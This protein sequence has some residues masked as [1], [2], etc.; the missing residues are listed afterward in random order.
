MDS[1]GRGEESTDAY[2]GVVLPS[3]QNQQPLYGEQHVQPAGGSPWGAPAQQ[4]GQAPQAPH[5]GHAAPPAADATQMLPPYPA[6]APPL[7]PPAIPPVAPD[8][9]AEATQVLRVQPAGPPPA[10]TPAMPAAPAPGA[11]AAADATQM[12]PPYP[13]GDPSLAPGAGPAGA[14]PFPPGYGQGRPQQQPG[15]PTFEQA[16]GSG[17]GYPG[18]DRRSGGDYPGQDFPGQGFG[19]QDYP[20]YPGQ[21]APGGPAYGD[22]GAGGGF[23]GPQQQPTGPEHDSDYD[24]LFRH[25]VPSP[26]P[27]RPHI[28]QRPDPQQAQA[29]P[30]YQQQPPYPGQAGHGH[31]NLPG[32]FDASY[33]DDDRRGGRRMSP[34]VIIGIVVAG[35]VVAGLVVGSLLNS[36]G[37]ASAN[38]SPD[39]GGASASSTAAPGTDSGGT[40]TADP[41]E[42]QAKELDALLQTSGDSR[43]QVISAVGSIKNCQNLDNAAS[44]L[45][46]AK[47]QRDGLVTKLGTLSL[48]RLPDHAA[49]SDALTRA[50][51]ASAAADSHY[52]SWAEQAKGKKVCK[53]GHAHSTAETAEGNRESGT[54]TEQKKRAVKLWNTIADKY[55]L[56]KRTYGQL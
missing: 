5:P 51:R 48:D 21:D 34:K 32:G 4:P 47:T 24:H 49:L 27:M 53:G 44:D 15:Q 11:P 8:Q 22:P 25:D 52:A 56:T 30:P 9:G 19:G 1:S 40:A 54:A 2:R 41:G 7:A 45:R 33:D 20:G 3:A 55:G 18:Q 29:Q 36:G 23:G 6:G 38:N 37:D 10:A 31:G 16:Y 26:A 39:K 28:I 17:A 13:G 35:C 43:S 50:W 46:A 12:L 42:Q 14:A